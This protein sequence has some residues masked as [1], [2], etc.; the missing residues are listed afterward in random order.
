MAAVTQE[1]LKSKEL[2]NIKEVK[3]R[4][5]DIVLFI[6]K[7]LTED[8]D[9]EYQVIE[10]PDMEDAFMVLPASVALSA[11]CLLCVIRQRLRCR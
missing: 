3:S 4:G 8:L 6:K 5:A 1:R 10:L 2:S 11:P 7:A 9:R